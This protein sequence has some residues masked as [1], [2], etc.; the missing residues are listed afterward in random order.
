VSE[1]P[2]DTHQMRFVTHEHRILGV[3]TQATPGRATIVWIDVA[4]S[5]EDVLRSDGAR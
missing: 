1:L 3:S 2:F 5:V 4:R